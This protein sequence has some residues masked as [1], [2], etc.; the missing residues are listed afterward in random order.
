MIGTTIKIKQQYRIH[1]SHKS[2][3]PTIISKNTGKKDFEMN[4]QWN[5]SSAGKSHSTLSTVKY[6]SPQNIHGINNERR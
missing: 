1:S 6:Q 4:H 3:K 2:Q 5:F